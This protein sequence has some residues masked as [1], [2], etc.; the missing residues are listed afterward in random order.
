MK[1]TES[2]YYDYSHF[3]KKFKTDIEALDTY[4]DIGYQFKLQF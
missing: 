4:N 3:P 2:K 1:A